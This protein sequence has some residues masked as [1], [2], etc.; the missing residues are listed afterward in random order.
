MMST[1]A[2]IRMVGSAAC[3]A[4]STDDGFMI[5]RLINWNRGFLS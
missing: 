5:N 3:F 2:L 4:S 1:R